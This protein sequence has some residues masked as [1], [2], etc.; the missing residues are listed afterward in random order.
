M[1]WRLFSF[2][3]NIVGCYSMCMLYL[4]KP[5]H[6]AKYE[7]FT[8]LSS[9]QVKQMF[10]TF[11]KLFIRAVG[12]VNIWSCLH[13]K[14]CSVV[15]CKSTGVSHTLTSEF[16]SVLSFLFSLLLRLLRICNSIN[17]VL[18]TFMW[19]NKYAIL[20]EEAT[21]V[22]VLWGAFEGGGGNVECLF[23]LGPHDHRVHNAFS[24]R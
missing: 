18:F 23:K 19:H 21:H 20:F 3:V 2:G 5:T 4:C 16:V 8:S 12:K 24:Q 6:F 1:I 11:A 10:I 7:L 9:L 15:L 14:G 22:C 17:C 13:D